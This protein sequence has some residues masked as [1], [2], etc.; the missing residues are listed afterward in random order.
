MEKIITRIMLVID[1]WLI[2]IINASSSFLNFFPILIPTLCTT[3]TI[4]HIQ[5]RSWTLVKTKYRNWTNI[6]L[7][8][9]VKFFTHNLIVLCEVWTCY[10]DLFIFIKSHRHTLL[11]ARTCAHTSMYVC[12]WRKTMHH[13]CHHHHTTP[14]MTPLML[15]SPLLLVCTYRCRPMLLIWFCLYLHSQQINIFLLIHWYM[16]FT[17]KHPL[18]SDWS[19]LKHK[20]WS[21]YSSHSRHLHWNIQY[22]Y[23]GKE[24]E[25]RLK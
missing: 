13:L 22:S 10:T 18:C 20:P 4:Q 24:M 25:F 23:L 3:Y 2:A 5:H 1:T 12:G 8:N 15:L 21:Q 19:K 6:L 7:E 17:A 9:R 14:M 16:I 11:H